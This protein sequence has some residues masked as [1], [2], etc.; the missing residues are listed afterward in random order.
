MLDGTTDRGVFTC[1]I[2]NIAFC[3]TVDTH[4]MHV[5]C[6]A[7]HFQSLQM[8][9][10]SIKD[11][12]GAIPVGESLLHSVGHEEHRSKSWKSLLLH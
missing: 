12:D 2:V 10:Q 7:P 11:I 9:F 5:P 6:V 3:E 8:S 4:L 1:F